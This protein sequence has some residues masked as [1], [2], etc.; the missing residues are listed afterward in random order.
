MS[1]SQTTNSAKKSP[2]D[3]SVIAE[4]FTSEGDKMHEKLGKEFDEKYR[5]YTSSPL[6]LH[7]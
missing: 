1:N 4:Q 6:D 3:V 5:E 2:N 7:D